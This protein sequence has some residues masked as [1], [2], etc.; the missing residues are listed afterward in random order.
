MTPLRTF[1]AV[2]STSGTQLA[3]GEPLIRLLGQRDRHDF[4]GKLENTSK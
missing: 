2:L 1:P 3:T 4:A